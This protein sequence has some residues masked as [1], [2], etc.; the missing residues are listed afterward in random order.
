MRVLLFGLVL[1]LSGC[2]YTNSIQQEQTAKQALLQCLQQNP[3]D[4]SKCNGLAA[5]Y[6]ISKSDL[7]RHQANL[8]NLGAQQQANQ[9]QQHMNAVMA[10]NPQYGACMYHGQCGTYQKQ[11]THTECRWVFGKMVCDSY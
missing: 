3:S 9:N 5:A 7:E 1:A 10:A 6:Q 2:A 4:A 11:N 8:Q